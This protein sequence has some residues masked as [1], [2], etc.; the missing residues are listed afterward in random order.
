MGSIMVSPLMRLLSSE[1]PPEFPFDIEIEG[2]NYHCVRLLRYLKNKRLTTE[3]FV[4]GQHVVLKLFKHNLFSKNHR[5]QELTNY[6][7]A[8]Q[9]KVPVPTLLREGDV[10]G[11]GFLVFDF[12][13]QAHP[14]NPHDLNTEAIFTF[15]ADLH[16]VGIY[17]SDF[18]F[19]N[20]LI[21]EGQ[22]YL[23]D[24][25]GVVY[26]KNKTSLSVKASLENLAMF[27]AQFTPE[28]QQRL[29]HS[30]EYYCFCRKWTNVDKTMFEHKYLRPA[31]HKRQKTVIEKCFRTCSMTIAKQ[32]WRWKYA[33]KRD[34]QFENLE[35]FVKNI[36]AMMQT[37]EMLKDGNSA[38]V[39]KVQYGGQTL[40]IK[41]YN[42]KSLWHGL[43]RALQTSRAENSW[44]YANVLDLLGI[45]TTLPL[46]YIES[47][48][49]PIRRHAYFVSMYSHSDDMALVFQ[50]RSPTENELQQIGRIF[51][52]LHHYHIAHGDLKATNWMIDEDGIVS[53][54]DLD[55]MRQVFSPSRFIKMHGRDKQ[56]FLRNWKASS[57]LQVFQE[58]LSENEK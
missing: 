57:H 34:F 37:G 10:E 14:I 54:I 23:L 56:R 8:A 38:T 43:K 33:F 45:P 51:R 6:Q 29:L 4:D 28:H 19:D 42:L 50:Q 13:E 40:V 12:L 49:G 22:Y 18:H 20:V 35:S 31:W 48:W 17:Q 11:M 24:M 36:D 25:G 30:F 41:R 47:R 44:R 9:R 27:I 3:A 39:V 53:L 55:A 52:L 32:N 2:Q 5:K 21:S 58:V 16:E 1:R 7:I 15:I 26:T 46:G